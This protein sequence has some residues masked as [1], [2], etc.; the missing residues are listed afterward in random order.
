MRFRV[1]TFSDAENAAAA[2]SAWKSALRLRTN[3]IIH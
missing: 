1:R 2:L 3:R